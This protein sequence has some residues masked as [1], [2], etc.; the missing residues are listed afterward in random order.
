ML[1]EMDRLVQQRKSFA[2]ETTLAGIG[3]ARKLSAWSDLGYSIS[4][5]FLRLP[6]VTHALDRVRARVVQGGHD[7]PEAVIRRWF[8]AGWRNF[9]SR[10]KDIADAWCVL[11]SNNPSVV[12]LSRYLFLLRAFFIQSLLPRPVTRIDSTDIMKFVCAAILIR[13]VLVVV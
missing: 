5:L 2:F 12:L 1:E 7:I 10:Y 3:Y 4:L 13:H 8:D 6:D 9:E 11:D